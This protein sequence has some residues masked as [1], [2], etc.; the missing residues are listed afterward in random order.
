MGKGLV[1]EL[2]S[3]AFTSLWCYLLEVAV[4][5]LQRGELVGP[6]FI[7]KRTSSGVLIYFNSH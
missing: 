1:L 5:M 4:V 7:L 6:I 2:L 3:P